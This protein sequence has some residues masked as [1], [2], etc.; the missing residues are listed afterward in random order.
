MGAKT[1][2]V[3]KQPALR[4]YSRKRGCCPEG[5]RR[6]GRVPRPGRGLEEQTCQEEGPA[7]PRRWDGQPGAERVLPGRQCGG[8]G[9]FPS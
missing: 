7:G 5:W 8:L 6:K 4:A 9:C 2:D 3:N 1:K